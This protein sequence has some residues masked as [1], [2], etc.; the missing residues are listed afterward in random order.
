MGVYYLVNVEAMILMLV[1]MMMVLQI[2][3]ES[4]LT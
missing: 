1:I 4:S 2:E 3:V